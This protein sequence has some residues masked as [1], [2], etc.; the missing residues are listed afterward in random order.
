MAGIRGGEGLINSLISVANGSFLS[1][2]G[3]FRVVAF[4]DNV[5]EN[6]DNLFI[7]EEVNLQGNNFTASSTPVL[8]ILPNTVAWVMASS[9]VYLNNRARVSPQG[10]RLFNAVVPT[11]TALLAAN[12]FRLAIISS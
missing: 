1:Y 10:S 2:N 6:E 3:S 12:N 9:A 5:I 7:G 11:A 4:T 8:Q